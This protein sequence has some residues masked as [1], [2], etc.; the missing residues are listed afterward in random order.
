MRQILDHS[1][2]HIWRVHAATTF[3]H[4]IVMGSK[5][6]DGDAEAPYIF[7]TLRWDPTLRNHEESDSSSP[8]YLLP[9]HADRIA[10]ACDN[11][12]DR[13]KDQ[14][15][16]PS[17][18]ALSRRLSNAVSRWC[19]DPRNATAECL[20]I[21]YRVY[22]D[23]TA[24]TECWPI[25]RLP[26]ST[27]FP[28]TFGTPETLPLE[29]IEW[30]VVLDVQDTALS[31]ST[32]C[33]TSDR[34]AYDRA[35]KAA[36]I[37]SLTCQQEVL[38]YSRDGHIMDASITSPYFYRDGQWATPSASCGGQHGTTRRWALENNLA[39][40]AVIDKD[41]LVQHDIVWLS[42]A[43]R[44]FFPARLVASSIGTASSDRT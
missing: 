8:F 41:G 16:A 18:G 26:R 5:D 15:Y 39:I 29:G 42:N 21:K 24:M 28:T 3:N 4:S 44:G 10:E 2:Q 12:P 25:P 13:S 34:W 31:H 27:L 20:R 30:T 36:G 33:K 32:M 35:R 40:E 9:Y 22:G 23:G 17:V 14:S 38:L 6:K 19:D 1:L 37:S 11:G 7:T 43:V